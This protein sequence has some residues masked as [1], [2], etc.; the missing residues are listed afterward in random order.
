[1]WLAYVNYP[2]VDA[3]FARPNEPGDRLVRGFAGEVYGDPADLAAAAEV[4]FARHNRDDR[5]DGQTAPSLSIGD[6]VVFGEVA[7]SVARSGFVPVELDAADLIVDRCWSEVADG[8]PAAVS[9]RVAGWRTDNGAGG[10]QL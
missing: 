5:P 9:T 6:V 2:N 4:V 1:M 7:V 8:L 10:V 3:G